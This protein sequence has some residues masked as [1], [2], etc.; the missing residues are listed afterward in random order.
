M[1]QKQ[2]NRF[3]Q[4]YKNADVDKKIELYCSTQ[5]LSEN[6]YMQML[7][8]FPVNKIPQLEKALR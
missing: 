2:F 3:F 8:V 4:D 1:D 5:D 6:Q 7:R